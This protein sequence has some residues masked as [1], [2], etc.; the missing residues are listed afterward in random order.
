MPNDATSPVPLWRLHLLR[1]SYL[2][3]AVGQGSRQWPR[4]FH[5]SPTWDIWHGVGVCLFAALAALCLLGVRNPLQMLPLML[6]ELVWKT[7][8]VLSVALPPW[9]GHQFVGDVADNF[10]G[11]GMGVVIVPLVIPWGYVW[12]QYVRQPAERWR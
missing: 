3:V 6:F 1:A 8:W 10:A 12:R 2:L 4:L 9:L 7:M 5:A 11:I